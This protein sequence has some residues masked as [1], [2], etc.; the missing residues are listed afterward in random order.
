MEGMK[1]CGCMKLVLGLVVLANIYWL[2][3][4]WW[5]VIGWVLVLMGIHALTMKGCCKAKK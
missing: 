5:T 4:D 3:A 1:H 2:K